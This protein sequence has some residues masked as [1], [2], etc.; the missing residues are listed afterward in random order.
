MPNF[1]LSGL[2]GSLGVITEGTV[3][4]EGTVNAW[5]EINAGTDLSEEAIILDSGSIQAGLP[6][7]RGSQSA[8][9]GYNVTGTVNMEHRDKGFSAVGG[10]GMGFWWKHALGSTAVPIVIA[11]TT[12]YKQ[13]HFPGTHSGLSFTTQLGLPDSTV[14]RPH[15]Y[16]GCK[17][18]E[19]EISCQDGGYLMA[20]FTIDGWK[21]NTSTSLVTP[22]YAASSYQSTPFTFADASTFTLGGTASTAS[23]V[24]S[25][26]G[27][28]PITTVVK[29]FS[30]KGVSPMAADRR[31]LG[32]SGI[33]REQIENGQWE[34]TGHLDAEYTLR[35]EIYDLFKAYTST[36]LELKFAH[37]DAG[38]G[39][40]YAFDIILPQV[41][42]QKAD[43]A[44]NGADLV[45]QST[46]FKAYSDSANP[47]VQIQLVSQDQAL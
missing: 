31:G 1:L 23:N 28:T 2:S 46:D 11:A 36:V 15:T 34:Y 13:S 22:A 16:R 3:G 9:A 10:K 25:V 45:T 29:G 38:G 20:K 5:Y 24:T 33:K 35:T 32:N 8:I 18:T 27:G 21:E 42:F 44:L 6:V 19:W 17:I 4:T 39:N 37:G 40:P 14:I 41:K 43:I 47:A 7:Q 30:L 26:S 12:A